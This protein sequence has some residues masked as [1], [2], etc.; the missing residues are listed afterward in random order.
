MRSLDSSSIS[1]YGKTIVH[2]D[3]SAMSDGMK[4]YIKD[5]I[6]T[7]NN[8]HDNMPMNS[9]DNVQQNMIQVKGIP[10]EWSDS[11]V[12]SYFDSNLTK[13][14]DIKPVLNKLGKRT[15]VTIL[16]LKNRKI[17]N[18]FIERYNNDY[19]ELEDQNYHLNVRMYELSTK[20]QSYKVEKSHRTVMIYDIPY[21]ATNVDI[22]NIS[23]R[24]GMIKSM[25]MPM[26]SNNKNR[27][28]CVIEYETSNEVQSLLDNE[29]GCSLF[30]RVLKFKTGEYLFTPKKN[31]QMNAKKVNRSDIIVKNAESSDIQIEDY[32]NNIVDSIVYNK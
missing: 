26:N 20:E 14:L 9:I 11:K 1:K 17:A 7:M 22:H 15:G 6:N 4:K 25:Y 16:V 2:T 21:E 31:N 23:K 13:I 29:E 28:Y 3:E 18:E 8:K 19:I 32:L 27:G 30:G 24:H 12:M 5:T 10:N